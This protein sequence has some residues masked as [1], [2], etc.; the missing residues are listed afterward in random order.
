MA[1]SKRDLGGCASIPVAP[2]MLE[3][4]AFLLPRILPKRS[5]APL[6]PADSKNIAVWCCS[7]R[8]TWAPACRNLVESLECNEVKHWF[9]DS[10][11]QTHSV[12]H[13]ECDLPTHVVEVRHRVSSAVAIPSSVLS[14][15]MASIIN[16]KQPDSILLS[17]AWNSSAH[18][19]A[20]P[21][22][23]GPRHRFSVS[24]ARRCA[25]VCGCKRDEAHV[26]GSW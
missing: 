16:S 9:P 18:S 12:E 10:L 21:C 6:L 19:F 20:E 4:W 25:V 23:F 2:T 15:V 7:C 14:F 11:I 1:P 8:S 5:I 13:L 3:L 17:G 26:S 22:F 24:C